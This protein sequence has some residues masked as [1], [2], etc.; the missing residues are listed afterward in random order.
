MENI[1]IN[2]KLIYFIFLILS[3]CTGLYA[4]FV[5]YIAKAGYF[6]A[7]LFTSKRDM[8]AI[9]TTS[10][11]FPLVFAVAFMIADTILWI[12]RWDVPVILL[13]L[14]FKIITYKAYE[15]YYLRKSKKVFNEI[16]KYYPVYHGTKIIAITLP[17]LPIAQIVFLYRYFTV[18]T[19][20]VAALEVII[21]VLLYRAKK[22]TCFI[23]SIKLFE[24]CTLLVLFY[25]MY[26][27]GHP[28]MYAALIGLLA[29]L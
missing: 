26:E 20:L 28:L 1:T 10:Y 14:G 4:F 12:V 21:M 18:F 11:V 16:H 6:N 27:H 15:Y 17:I 25:L 7:Q 8:D 13:S 24:V 19:I 2:L 22:Y 23:Y 9:N 3:F 29:V 5:M